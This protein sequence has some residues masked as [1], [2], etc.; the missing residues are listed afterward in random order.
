MTTQAHS[1]SPVRVLVTGGGGFLGSHI[2]DQL[3]LE[4]S[5]LV[6]ITS[7]NPHV[8]MKNDRLSTHP[9]DLASSADIQGI[10]NSFKPHVVIHTA[11]PRHTDSIAALKRANIEGTN[12]L[13]NCAKKC[14][15]T[16]AFIYTSSD[17][18][19]EPS[20]EPLTEEHAKLYDDHHFPNPYGLTKAVADAAVQA[21]NCDE[22]Y[23]VVLRVPG[24]YGEKDTSGMTAQFASSVRKKEHKMQIGQ[25]KKSFEF[26]YAGK[27]AEAHVLAMRALM[28]PQ[29]AA[30]VA[31]EAFFITDGKPQ[32]FFEFARRCYAS[33]GSPVAPDEVTIIP[34]YAMQLMASAGE[35]AYFIF[36]LGMVK[37][38]LR[39]HGIDH[40]DKN[41]CWSIQKA[42]KRLGYEPI[43]DQDAAIKRSMEWAVANT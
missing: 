5:T 26:V 13:L 42:R 38:T 34:M 11:S 29:K 3:L 12:I 27:A 41:C 9:A 1:Q 8:L 20:E 33:I 28:N 22:L 23:T 6:A 40:L 21:A 18:A 10:F 43:D 36:T 14:D 16:R 37:P 7:R 35:W 39:R 4:P 31:G 24:I 19:V 17:S 32:P 15:T 25:N 2:V 30:G